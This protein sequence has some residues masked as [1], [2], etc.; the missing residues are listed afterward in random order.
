MNILYLGES[1]VIQDI[2]DD[3]SQDMDF[4]LYT[5]DNKKDEVDIVLADLDYIDIDEVVDI[6]PKSSI[7]AIVSSIDEKIDDI[8]TIQKPFLPKDIIDTISKLSSDIK[9]TEVLNL[10]EIERVKKLLEETENI[11][12]EESLESIDIYGSESMSYNITADEL[13]NLLERV[14][15]KRLRKLLKGAVIDISIRFPKD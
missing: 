1:R 13:I 3:I 14:K 8:H 5:D 6:Y 9:K 15:I 12:S 4:I 11:S 2:L 7:I 10:E